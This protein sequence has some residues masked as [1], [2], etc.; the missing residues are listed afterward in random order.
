MFQLALGLNAFGPFRPFS[1][2]N[3]GLEAISILNVTWGGPMM[4]QTGPSLVKFN[5]EIAYDPIFG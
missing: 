1:Q 3:M 2:S 4:E 5:M